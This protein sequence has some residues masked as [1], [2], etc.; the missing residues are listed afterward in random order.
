MIYSDRPIGMPT[1][2]LPWQIKGSYTL[3]PFTLSSL[4]L[5]D[6]P[7]LIYGLL[8]INYNCWQTSKTDSFSA[9]MQANF[10]RNQIQVIYR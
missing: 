2:I 4:V 7:A 9:I 8:I 10:D 1:H 3:F 5:K 6:Q